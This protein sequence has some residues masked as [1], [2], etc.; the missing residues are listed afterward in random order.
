MMSGLSITFHLYCQIASIKNLICPVT[1]KIYSVSDVQAK[2]V[3]FWPHPQA[4]ATLKTWEWPGDEASDFHAD[5]RQR[6]TVLSM[7]LQG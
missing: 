7:I 1:N 3:I 5:Y 2:V 6:L 4:T